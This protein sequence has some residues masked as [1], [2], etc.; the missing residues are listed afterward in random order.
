[1][2]PRS[3]RQIPANVLDDRAVSTDASVRGYDD[4]VRKFAIKPAPAVFAFAPRHPMTRASRLPEI[5]R[6]VA[7]SFQNYGVVEV[8]EVR[9]AAP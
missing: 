9:I 6:H 1:M 8:A 2:M 7:E 4:L 3:Q 5:L